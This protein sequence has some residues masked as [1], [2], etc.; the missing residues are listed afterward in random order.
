M[1]KLLTDQGYSEKR[2]ADL[3]HQLAEQKGGADLP[4]ASPHDSATSRTSRRFVAFCA[5]PTTKQMMKYTYVC[6]AVGIGL[7]G[8]LQGG[9]V[10]LGAILDSEIVMQ[11]GGAAVFFAFLLFAFPAYAAFQRRMNRGKKLLVCVGSGDL[12]VDTR[13]GGRF[14]IGDVQGAATELW[15]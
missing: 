8:A 14:G 7:V 13:P 15:K 3:E 9:M 4:P 11:V 5:P 10:L 6:I 12:T 1:D 2:I